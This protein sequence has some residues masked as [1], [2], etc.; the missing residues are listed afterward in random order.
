MSGP[1]YCPIC[2]R[3]ARLGPREADPANPSRARVVYY[4][5]SGGHRW[6]RVGVALDVPGPRA[7]ERLGAREVDPA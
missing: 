4:E 2:G 6:R 5:C 7:V 1:V 3:R